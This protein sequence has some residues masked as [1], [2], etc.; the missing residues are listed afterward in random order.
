MKELTLGTLRARLCGGTDRE[1][2]GTGPVVIL[3]HGFG[4]PGTAPVVCV[5]NFAPVVREGY[6]VGLPGPGRWQQLLNTDATAYGGSGIGHHDP[7]EAEDLLPDLGDPPLGRALRRHVRIGQRGAGVP[8]ALGDPLRE[9]RPAF[10]RRF[11]GSGG[12]G[13]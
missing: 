12:I 7:L 1:G 9:L 6:R 13:G 8:G 2:G 11:G 3:M 5:C 10:L 4:A